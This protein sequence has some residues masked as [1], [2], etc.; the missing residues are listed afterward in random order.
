M[1]TKRLVLLGATGETGRQALVAALDD[2]RVSSVH[3]FG[4]SAPSV[5]A[6]DKLK[7]ESLD[8]EALLNEGAAGGPE[9]AKLRE[10][11][12]DAVLVALGTTRANAGSAERFERIDRE[13]V[14]AA[15]RAARREGKEQALV[16]VSV[17][18]ALSSS[19]RRS[20]LVARSLGAAASA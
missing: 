11:D 15:A 5:P 13:Y 20:D 18:D 17:R 2:A 14:L 9:S 10:A 3:T 12:A 6:N 8:F 7:H 19:C 16:Y 4:R 1:S